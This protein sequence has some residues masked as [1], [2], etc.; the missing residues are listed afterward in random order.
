MDLSSYSV[1]SFTRRRPL[2]STSTGNFPSEEAISSSQ[3]Q[4]QPPSSSSAE[5]QQGQHQHQQQQ[6][7]RTLGLTDVVFYGVGCSVGAG[8]YSLVGIGAELAGPSIA[9]SF[10]VCGIACTFTSLSYAEF[11]AR[12]P[13]AGSAYTFTYVSFGELA[14][15]LVGWNLTLGY[16]VSAAVVAQSW[17]DY[18]VGFLKGWVNLDWTYW[19]K[20][21]YTAPMSLWSNDD[22]DDDQSHQPE[23]TCCPMSMVIIG[24]CTLILVTGV[25]ESARFNTAMT[26][27][28]LSILVFVLIAGIGSGSVHASDNLLP[29]FPKGIKGM[30]SGAGL[31][32]F[33]Y[34]GFDMVACLSE[35]CIDPNRNM[36]RGIIG[37]LFISMAIYVS[38]SLVVVGMAPINLLGRDT[39]ITSALLA[40]A[41][42]NAEQQ[43]VSTAADSCLSYA[44]CDPMIHPILFV[45]SKFISFGAIFGLT[46][47]TFACLMGQPR[48]TFAA[49]NDGLLFPIFSRLNPRTGVPT[50]GTLLT[51]VMTAFVA[52]FIDLEVL[53]NAISLGTL[54]VF[55]FVNAGV[56]LLRMRGA[57]A[58][59]DPNT[60]VDE[61]TPLVPSAR[62]PT[63]AESSDKGNGMDIVATS[64]SLRQASSRQIRRVVLESERGFLQWPS[65]S[66][67]LPVYQVTIFTIAAIIAALGITND[68]H[69]YVTMGS[70]LAMLGSTVLLCCHP[71][72]PPPTQTF[73]CPAVPIVPLLGIMCNCYMMGSLPLSTWIAIATW[74][75]V[76]LVF[77]LS[78]GIHHSKLQ[79]SNSATEVTGNR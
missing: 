66:E 41:C 22:D 75:F 54:Q 67:S 45:G 42:C 24:V 51:G 39:P 60:D 65:E 2:T 50:W 76:G 52:C 58:L 31:V 79:K 64:L 74:L 4:H 59:N 6:L 48:I 37:S 7:R 17:A 15:W 30:A 34:L 46:T 8:I 16:A 29:F 78:Y 61:S 11:A 68:W 26:I 13:L 57:T 43:K 38:V 32:F 70:G 1:K 5:Q 73:A 55:S 3:Q 35:E 20:F 27:L 28:N 36:P 49:A 63:Y 69:P 71:T 12:V 33:S 44:L 47:A 53:A 23:Y 25:K 62:G 9:V 10:L 56:I 21:P 72:L 19:T 14:A 18:L 77:Y 40:N